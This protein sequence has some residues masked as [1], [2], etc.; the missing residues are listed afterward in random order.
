MSKS[1]DVRRGEETKQ[2]N[3]CFLH[4]G[5]GCAHVFCRASGL[6]GEVVKWREGMF[7]DERLFHKYGLVLGLHCSSA[8]FR[9]RREEGERLFSKRHRLDLVRSGGGFPILANPTMMDGTKFVR[10]TCL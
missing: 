9:R 1:I 3:L 10:M 2:I 5:G 4:I 8:A 6:G 7:H